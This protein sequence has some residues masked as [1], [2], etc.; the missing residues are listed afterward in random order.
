MS[1]FFLPPFPGPSSTHPARVGSVRW[2]WLQFGGERRLERTNG[3][4]GQRHRRR[5]QHHGLNSQSG[6]CLEFSVFP[7]DADRQGG[8]D[9]DL[10]G[11][12]RLA[13]RDE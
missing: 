7:V 13:H 5:D 2:L 6:Q 12:Q 4:G 3:H 8:D 9:G 1:Q 11:R 10:E